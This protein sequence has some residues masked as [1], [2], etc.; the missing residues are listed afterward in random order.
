[1][2]TSWENNKKSLFGLLAAI[3]TL[4]VVNVIGLEGIIKLVL[5]VVAFFVGYKLADRKSDKASEQK[6]ESE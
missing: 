4:A 5:A 3:I 1:M 2:D 6:S